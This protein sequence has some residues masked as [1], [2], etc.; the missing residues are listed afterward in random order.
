M[1]TIL[2]G[3]HSGPRKT[4]HTFGEDFG[5]SGWIPAIHWLPSGDGQDYSI[6]SG[7]DHHL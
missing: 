4:P 2:P 1:P 6:Y 5:E 3:I 7:V